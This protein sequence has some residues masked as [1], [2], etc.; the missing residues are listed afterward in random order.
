MKRVY[1]SRGTPTTE[2]GILTVG[3]SQVYASFGDP[4]PD[5]AIGL[6]LYWKPLI[7]LIWLGPVI[8]AAGGA[9]S[10]S[11]R[12]FRVGAPVRARPAGPAVAAAE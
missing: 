5:G 3:L 2:A 6:R 11:D 12:R 4:Q 10:L 1:T 9:L 8:M 7:L